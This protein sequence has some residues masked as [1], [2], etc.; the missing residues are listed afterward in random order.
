MAG[1]IIIPSEF[2]TFL[3]RLSLN[4]VYCEL[5]I[6]NHSIIITVNIL[7]TVSL[8]RNVPCDFRCGNI[9]QKKAF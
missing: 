4:T 5:T 3:C 1:K 2:M 8:Q 9:R 7:I 6:Y